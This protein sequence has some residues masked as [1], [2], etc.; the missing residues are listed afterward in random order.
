MRAIESDRTGPGHADGELAQELP[1]DT[2]E[3]DGGIARAHR[4]S[5][6][7]DRE[8]F[9]GALL[10][11]DA[12]CAITRYPKEGPPV[13]ERDDRAVTL[14]PSDLARTVGDAED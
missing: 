7:V 1:P 4:D 13:R 3:L 8:D 5:P 14:D 12:D 11:A 2:D 9:E 6:S 10:G